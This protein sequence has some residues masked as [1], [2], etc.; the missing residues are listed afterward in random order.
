MAMVKRV[1]AST[2]DTS[3]SKISLASNCKMFVNLFYKV[4]DAYIDIDIDLQVPI[5]VI[6]S[7]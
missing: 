5:F 3:N 7:R 1:L 6:R 4:K 2:H